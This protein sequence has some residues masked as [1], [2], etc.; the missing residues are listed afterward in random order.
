MSVISLFFITIAL[1][2]VMLLV[3]RSLSRS[4][5]AG[6][7][8]WSLANV[9][10]IGALL[11]YVARGRVPDLLS[12]ETANLLFLCAPVTMYAGF[13][14]HL[15][16]PVPARRL[17]A[18]V[19]VSTGLLALIHHASDSV[20]WRIA[21]ASASHGVVYALILHCLAWRA[22]PA[23]A[24][25]PQ[26]FSAGVALV[27]MAIHAARAVIYAAQGDTAVTIFDHSALNLAFFS[28]GTLALPALTLGAVMMANDAIIRRTTWAAEHDHLTGAW[29]RRAF[30]NLGEREHERAQR[31]GNPLSV[32]VFDVDHFKSINDS[33]GH[34]AGDQVLADIVLR[35]E[36]AIRSVDACARLGGEEFAVLLPDTGPDTARLVA[37]RLRAA[38]DQRGGEGQGQVRYTVSIGQA[39]LAPGESLAGLLKRA[40]AALYAAK[41]GGR[42]RVC[43]AGLSP[44]LN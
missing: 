18:G 12:I 38:L 28:F 25:Y 37:E 35:T 44:M 22:R 39:T 36:A 43:E 24:A 5:V 41:A 3:L 16:R 42:N 1:S 14:Q 11:L 17:C 27:L 20:A 10:A 32:L 29:S 26:R 13:L 33:H 31:S 8:A 4:G 23:G 34:A 30:F 7:R 2:A 6:V 19:V 40:D 15:G 21:L 9:L